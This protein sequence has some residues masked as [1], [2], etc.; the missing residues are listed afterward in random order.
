MVDTPASTLPSA[1]GSTNTDPSALRTSPRR[2]PTSPKRLVKDHRLKRISP[3]KSVTSLGADGLA[4]RSTLKSTRT[5]QTLAKPL[6]PVTERKP[7][8]DRNLSKGKKDGENERWE[9]A[10][11]GSSAGREGRH[12]TV[13]NVGNNGRIYLRYD[14]SLET[15]KTHSLDR[16]ACTCFV[17][18]SRLFSVLLPHGSGS[19]RELTP[20]QANRTT[21]A[22]KVSPAELHLSRHPTRNCWSRFSNTETTEPGYRQRPTPESMDTI[23]SALPFR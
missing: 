20:F 22:S 18:L 19:W 2:N 8:D 23:A 21:G 3:P 7:Q 15:Y 1:A 11:D 16:V 4:G 13:A 9:M 6:V 14:S 10:P 17:A 12:F 5:V